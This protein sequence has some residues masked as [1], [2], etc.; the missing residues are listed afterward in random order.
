MGLWVLFEAIK[1]DSE[2]GLSLLLF[3][4]AVTSWIVAEDLVPTKS[5]AVFKIF[6]A[7]DTAS[8]EITKFS[9]NSWYVS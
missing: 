9:N 4:G 8:G 6:F 1:A 5:S 2:F 7:A 3:R